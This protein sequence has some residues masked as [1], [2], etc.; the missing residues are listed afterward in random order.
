MVTLNGYRVAARKVPSIVRKQPG[1]SGDGTY[2][3]LATASGNLRLYKAVNGQYMDASLQDVPALDI[4]R[5]WEISH[6]L[7]PSQ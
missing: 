6:L 5:A 3:V 7:N 2:C 4:V 1:Y